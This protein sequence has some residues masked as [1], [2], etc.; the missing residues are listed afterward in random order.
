MSQRNDPSSLSF[1]A[2]LRQLEVEASSSKRKV[3]EFEKNALDTEQ[4][5]DA[6]E[7]RCIKRQETARASALLTNGSGSLAELESIDQ[8]LLPQAQRFLVQQE[9]VA[10]GMAAVMPVQIAL[11]DDAWTRIRNWH[12]SIPDKSAAIF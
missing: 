5:A 7:R 2:R 3:E 4:K 8:S 6:N 9:L 11:T 1:G 12:A 10:R